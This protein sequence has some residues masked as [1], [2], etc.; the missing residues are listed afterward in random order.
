MDEAEEEDLALALEPR[1]FTLLCRNMLHLLES[2]IELT[3]DHKIASFLHPGFKKEVVNS[4][5]ITE[6]DEVI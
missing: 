4:L 6:K 1:P 2:T 5:P 3:V